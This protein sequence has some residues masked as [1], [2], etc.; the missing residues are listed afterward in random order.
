MHSGGGNYSKRESSF[1]DIVEAQVV[2]PPP[3]S[4]SNSRTK[5]VLSLAGLAA[6]ILFGVIAATVW[7]ALPVKSDH[8]AASAARTL[9]Q[10]N[11]V[12]AAAFNTRKINV[13][14]RELRRI[15]RLFN[16]VQRAVVEE[17]DEAFR[18]LV[19]LD[20]FVRA[21]N[22]S[23]EVTLSRFERMMLKLQLRYNLTAPLGWQSYDIVHV[24]HLSKDEAIVYAFLRSE[25]DFTSS[26]WWMARDGASWKVY[27]WD[28]LDYDAHE[29]QT[30]AA[31]YRYGERRAGRETDAAFENLEEA[32]VA[33]DKLE[34]KTAIAL[35]RRA[36]SRD[37]IPS[38]EAN[39]L[40]RMGWLYYMCEEPE[41]ALECFQQIKI[42]AAAPGAYK[43]LAYM[44]Q[45]LG[46]YE[47]GLEAVEG[48]DE[49]IG[50]NPKTERM[51][52]D[53]LVALEREE[54]AVASWER[55]L[56]FD[57]DDS[58]TLANLLAHLPTDQ[59]EVVDTYLQRASE[60]D[61]V[62]DSLALEAQW[63]DD[64]RTLKFLQNFLQRHRPDSTQ[65][66]YVNGILTEQQLD[67]AAAADFYQQARQNER[68]ED[69]RSLYLHNYLSAMQADGRELEAYQQT[70]DPTEAYQYLTEGY[71]EYDASVD[72]T[73]LRQLTEAHLAQ[74]P[75]DP[76]GHF[77][78]G[79]LLQEA[80]EYDKA[81]VHLQKA[82]EAGEA[83]ETS[84]WNYK[85][86]EVL[87]ELG[88]VEEAYRS[89]ETGD[90]GFNYLANYARNER[91]QETLG[92]LLE[93]HRAAGD[94]EWLDY[95]DAAYHQMQGDIEQAQELLARGLRSA[96]D[97]YV[98]EMYRAEQR[99]L[100]LDAGDPLE[101]Y[102]AVPP[103]EEAFSDLAA[104]L[105]TERAWSQLD[106]L[107]ELHRS[108]APDDPKITYYEA[109]AAW[110]REDY[111]RVI[112]VLAE[113]PEGLE[114]WEQDETK[115]WYV[116][117]LVRLGRF[118]A[119][120]VAS[121][122]YCGAAED[123]LLLAVV[124]AAQRDVERVLQELPGLD[125]NFLYSDEDVGDAMLEDPQ[126]APLRQ[127]HPPELY[128]HEQY[129]VE[130]VL[131][132]REEQSVE[133]LRERVQEALNS[134]PLLHSWTARVLDI[135]VSPIVSFVTL[136]DSSP[137]QLLLTAGTA[138]YSSPH[139]VDSADVRERLTDHAQW[140]AVERVRQTE[141]EQPSD[142]A[143]DLAARLANEDCIAIY[144]PTIFRLLPNTP[145]VRKA[146]RENDRRQ[147]D[148]TG[149]STWLSWSGWDSPERDREHRTARRRLPELVAAWE[150]RKAH[151]RYELLIQLQVGHAS[152]SHWL[153]L[154]RIEQPGGPEAKYIAVP[155][156][157]SQLVATFRVGEPVALYR[158]D[159]TNWRITSGERVQWGLDPAGD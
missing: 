67:Y 123:K 32:E 139:D 138:P 154:E 83:E 61:E 149:D 50:F 7:L 101:A 121:R 81:L 56:E 38:Y 134:D 97:E 55:L 159:I 148:E 23:D 44:Y 62:I 74:F 144:L 87:L 27:D 115:G 10:E 71:T 89:F 18:Q 30:V 49:A 145:E 140:L 8:V 54:E 82:L 152:E 22:R 86:A 65:L 119:A 141:R 40:I 135:D 19:D 111:E 102:R 3:H 133:Q 100:Y 151:D 96:S 66:L 84:G 153:T 33:V 72:R 117:S 47:K 143:Y 98:R 43:G 9:D 118:E 132:F 142:G 5:W 112:D 78:Q 51:R 126:L 52:A 59:Q 108:N 68:D 64:V 80:G 104:T 31:Y 1:G 109:Y 12:I 131:F 99:E 41:A 73:E 46:E 70:D 113:C 158:D 34:Y 85:Y 57:P 124:H 157:D 60:P 45:H 125:A 6:V 20:R 15:Q 42:P 28:L 16:E 103:A 88:R 17:D 48:Y 2:G 79:I 93:L 146:L 122:Q 106:E 77:H 58:T 11:A 69:R 91:Q 13:N 92:K 35:M 127:R 14:A 29:S 116:R 110:L 120:K 4:R 21:V 24:D 136:I 90:D 53:L 129:A 155:A 95:Y 39:M 26:R 114:T 105:A 63:S 94:D 137:G 25:D 36:A 76:W 156:E 75:E 130:S 128:V 37:V 107:I 147:L 150:Q